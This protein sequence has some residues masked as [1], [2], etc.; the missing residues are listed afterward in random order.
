RHP[1]AAGTPMRAWPDTLAYHDPREPPL[2]QARVRRSPEFGTTTTRR[3][4][5]RDPA[6]A[7]D[8]RD[9]NGHETGRRDRGAPRADDGG[10]RPDG[11]PHLPAVRWREPDGIRL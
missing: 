8:R 11:T 3:G 1:T 2:T 10:H 6:G 4:H 5:H 7:T 9:R